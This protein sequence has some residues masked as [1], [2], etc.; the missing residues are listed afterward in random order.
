[1]NV[2]TRE[3]LVPAEIIES[4]ELLMYGAIGMTTIALSAASAR[5]LTLSQWRALVVLG[6]NRAVRVGEISAAVGMSLPS[7]SRMIRRLEQRG[8]VATARDESDR[9]ATLVSVT[10]AG[11]NLRDDVV[12][13]RRTL[14]EAALAART[15]TLPGDLSDGLD[16]IAKAFAEYE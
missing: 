6:R 11:R 4:L 7:T 9:R 10:R 13:R 5:E 12:R 1:M 16:A 14:M 8:L 3:F 2:A 15:P